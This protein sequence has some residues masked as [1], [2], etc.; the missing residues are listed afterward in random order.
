MA[1]ILK[2]IAVLQALL[3]VLAVIAFFTVLP[4]QI[5]KFSNAVTPHEPYSVDARAKALHQS[6]IVADFHADPTLW[7]RDLRQRHTY[8]HIDLPRMREGNQALQV[9]TTVTKSPSGQNYQNNSADNPDSIT[10]LAVAQRW[11]VATWSNLTERAL[12]QANML[13]RMAQKAPEEFMLVTTQS[14]LT[15]FLEM[16]AQGSQLIAG[17]IGTEGSHALEGDINNVQRLYDKGFRMMSLQHFFDN[18]LGGSLHGI[19][20]GGLTEFGI[21]VVK[22]IDSMPILLDVSHS[23]EQVVSDVLKIAKHPLV[24]SHTGTHGHCATARNISDK[25]MQQI[26]KKGGVIAIGFWDAAVC[27]YSPNGIAK[28]IKAA[29]ELLGEDHV[30]LGSDF[31][32]AVETAMDASEFPAITHALLEQGIEERVIRKVMG[33]NFVR[34]FMARLPE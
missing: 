25:L 34:L 2:R 5:D 30:A 17:L 27:D 15:T 19:S 10:F 3:L 32:G 21:K 26:A 11:P 20:K 12:Y 24:V 33:E 7:S 9:F 6:L 29:I 18:H 23:S 31:D 13:H 28:A 16:R 4:K 1:S 8:G 14:E 22:K